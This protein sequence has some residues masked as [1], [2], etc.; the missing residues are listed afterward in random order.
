M[1][2]ENSA[3]QANQFKPVVIGYQQLNL[4]DEGLAMAC[5]GFM[6]VEYA[7]LLMTT[8]YNAGVKSYLRPVYKE[9]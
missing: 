4:C 2:Y 9:Q 8:N 5:Y 7:E 3:T 6:S 1:S